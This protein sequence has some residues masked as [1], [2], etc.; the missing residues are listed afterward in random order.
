MRD[1]NF[2]LSRLFTY[3]SANTPLC[4]SVASR[5]VSSLQLQIKKFPW[6]QVKF[7]RSF[8][9]TFPWKSRQITVMLKNPVNQLQWVKQ[10]KIWRTKLLINEAGSRIIPNFL[11]LLRNST[12]WKYISRLL[13]PMSICDLSWNR[14]DF[15]GQFW[16]VDERFAVCP[17]RSTYVFITGLANFCQVPRILQV[18]KTTLLIFLKCEAV[19]N[20]FSNVY[21]V[22]CQRSSYVFP[23]S[24][25]HNKKKWTSW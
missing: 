13:R 20:R 25:V 8:W 18:R 12:G 11:F 7:K 5:E 22:I 23:T 19:S 6:K 3:F 9:K 10:I 21:Y 2:K 1:F 14:N 16:V 4:C 15:R 24:I 17:C